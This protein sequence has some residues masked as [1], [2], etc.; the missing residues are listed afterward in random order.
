M[1]E[2]AYRRHTLDGP[3][4]T[5]SSA[6]LDATV[7]ARILED[8]MELVDITT[9]DADGMGIE[10]HGAIHGAFN[11]SLTKYLRKRGLLNLHNKDIS[12]KS[13][14]QYAEEAANRESHPGLFEGGRWQR[15]L[16]NLKEGDE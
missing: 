7:N 10:H 3:E 15:S 4:P 6:S 13:P 8:L 1:H 14:L 9:H 11:K 12:G 2:Y 5:K 16:Q